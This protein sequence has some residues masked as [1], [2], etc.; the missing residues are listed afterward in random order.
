MSGYSTISDG[1]MLSL[2]NL[3]TITI[4]D[5]I[6][7]GVSGDIL[8]STKTLEGN[9]EDAV[10]SFAS[11]KTVTIGPGIRTEDFMKEV[12]DNNGYG[13]IV[14]SAA[15]V[16][17]G[18]FILGG[19]YGLQSRMYG[20]AIDNVVGLEVVLPSGEIKEVKQDDDLFWAL[21]GAGGG[22]IGIVTKLEYRVYPSHD[23]KLAAS[24][25]VSLE[26][27][28]R[29][30]QLIGDKEP[31][32][33]P[34]FALK[35]Q[36]YSPTNEAVASVHVPTT[37]AELDDVNKTEENGHVTI[38][39]YWMGDSNPDDPV[40]M[41]Y[42]KDKI[43]PLFSNASEIDNLAYYYFSWSG[44]SREREQN[45][46]MKS[47]WSARSWNGFLLPSNNTKDIWMD[48]ESSLSAVFMYCRFVTPRIEL[49]GGAISK[50]P[51]NATVFP[52][53]NAVYNVGIDVIV[54]TE[55]D[56]DDA[57]DEINLVNAIWPSIERHL[58]GVYVNFPMASLSNI[59]YPT[60]YWGGNLDRLAS[61]TER[62]DPS[63]V[64]RVSQGVPTATSNTAF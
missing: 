56:A 2:A 39:M 47:V 21:C 5:Q 16:G 15:G 13:G 62:Y 37:P 46:E 4:N 7:N 20:L 34:E 40:G 49:W 29:F 26:E 33:A 59:S 1:V 22:N 50:I 52:H 36:G 55:S 51:S 3:N 35:V 24:V 14:A 60:A 64:L 23:I 58:D 53:R 38:S 61:L 17:M 18:G 19:G 44:M 9:N 8:N 28:T 57:S 30:L 27:M 12:L 6:S 42:I 31:Y 43:V 48:I 32:L 25:K 63:H 11:S 54:P 41:Q 45:A 10:T